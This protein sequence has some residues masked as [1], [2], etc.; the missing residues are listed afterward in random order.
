VRCGHAEEMSG[1]MVR[2]EE[3]RE[4]VL[5]VE[6]VSRGVRWRCEGRGFTS[7]PVFVLVNGWDVRVG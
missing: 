5:M 3:D 1:G 2:G 4:G 6:M 7:W